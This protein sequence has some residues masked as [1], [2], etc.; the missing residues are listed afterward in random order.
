V[1]S[2]SSTNEEQVMAEPI[3]SVVENWIKEV[4]NKKQSVWNRDIYA[5]KLESLSKVINKET[6][7][8]YKER[9]RQEK[10]RRL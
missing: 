5:Q 8:F 4:R 6:A 1:V 3:P 2:R 7:R 9:A 10:S